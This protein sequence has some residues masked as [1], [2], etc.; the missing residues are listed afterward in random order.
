MS[1]HDVHAQYQGS[2]GASGTETANAIFI[3][4]K[5]K[6]K[7][8]KNTKVTSLKHELISSNFLHLI[9]SMRTSGPNFFLKIVYR[10]GITMRQHVNETKYF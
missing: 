6:V 3:E 5:A 4:Y 1:S 2:S 7:I 8:F 10:I 9:I